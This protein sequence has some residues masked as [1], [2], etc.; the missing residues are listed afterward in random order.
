MFSLLTL[1]PLRLT[2]P[3]VFTFAALFPLLPGE[4]SHHQPA[5]ARP[6]PDKRLTA[7]VSSC[8]W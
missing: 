4:R 3:S 2:E 8:R 1:L 6:S 7:E 5:L